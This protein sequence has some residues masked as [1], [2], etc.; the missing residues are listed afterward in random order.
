MATA[1]LPSKPVILVVEDEFLLRI[2]A[3]DMLSDAG[4]DPIEA[5]NADEAIEIL[6]AR[7]DI[8]LIFTD[9]QMPGTMDGQKLA[10]MVRDR[11]PPIAIILTSGRVGVA[12]SELPQMARFLSKPYTERQ[13]TGA[14][15][16]LLN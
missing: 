8:R 3:T 12:N 13:L 2:N 15:S 11:W 16:E 6:D 5:A 1:A 9:I 14:I 10:S 7:S 4:F